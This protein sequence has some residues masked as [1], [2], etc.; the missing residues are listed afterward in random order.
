VDG[1]KETRFD[2]RKALADALKSLQGGRPDLAEA[3]LGGLLEQIPDNVEA[4]FA[5]GM[6]A[7]ARGDSASAID[8]MRQALRVDPRFPPA[9]EWLPVLYI[10][11]GKSL[12]QQFLFAEAL[13]AFEQAASLSTGIDAQ[14]EL[15]EMQTLVGRFSESVDTFS[16]ALAVDPNSFAASLL[17]ARALTNLNRL[18]EADRCWQRAETIETLPGQTRLAKALALSLIGEFGAA[19]EE[20]RKALD[21]NPKRGKAYYLLC[22]GTKIQEGDR[23]LVDRME[24]LTRD[25]DLGDSD[26]VDLHY[27]LG[28]AYDDLGEYGSAIQNFDQA[29]ALLR[30]LTFGD[31]AFDREAFRRNID[32]QIETFTRS[33]L[34]PDGDQG[35]ELP[36]FVVGMIRS[37]TTLVDQILTCH[38]EVGSAGEQAFWLQY[39]RMA[40][41]QIRT[42]AIEKLKMGYTSL[43]SCLAPGFPRVIDKNPANVLVAGLLHTVFPSSRIICTRRNA[44]DTALSIWMT[45]MQT[46][47]P[48]IGD[49]SDIVFAYKQY[50]RLTRHWQIAMP[51]SR[52][53]EVRYEDLIANPRDQTR[54]ML[55][56]CG[57]EWNEACL[58]PERNTRVIRTPSFWQ[59]RQPVYRTSMDRWKKYQPWLGP[60]ADLVAL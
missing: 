19:R 8:H 33:R 60:F 45:Q 22:A 57:L 46:H 36:L 56:F 31:R 49:R 11:R 54:A 12:R 41:E 34:S 58:H 38:P 7:A 13:I 40:M 59:V 52:Y 21:L 30:R 37:G 32:F 48:F 44:A 51:E 5:M 53:L 39:E 10:E 1:S 16:R 43:L 3:I 18:G 27:A 15:A 6:S 35:R 23:P 14:L 2:A 9:L 25:S 20:A 26:R 29:N 50:L 55:D 24:D 28:K 4:L 42:P 47:A 17:M